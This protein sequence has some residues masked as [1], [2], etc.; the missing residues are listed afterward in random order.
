[1]LLIIGLLWQQQYYYV[2][3]L[4]TLFHHISVVLVFPTF[5]VAHLIT[6]SQN[7]LHYNTLHN[8]IMCFHTTIYIQ[9][10]T[11][12]QMN[13]N[14]QKTKKLVFMY[15]AVNITFIATIIILRIMVITM[16]MIIII[17]II[18]IMYKSK[19]CIFA[20]DKNIINSF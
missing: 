7:S 4:L 5:C 16:M 15:D 14:L 17:N 1:M 10:N 12:H 20:K 6:I 8:I 11:I 2:I 13:T 9:P 19:S 3:L 18:I